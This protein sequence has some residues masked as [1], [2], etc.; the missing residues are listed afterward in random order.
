MEGRKQGKIVVFGS[1]EL[2]SKIAV[3]ER[4]LIERALKAARDT[5][6][7][8]AEPGIRHQTAGIF[9]SM[10]GSQEAMIVAD[11]NTY[12][13]AGRAVEA[14]FARE[15]RALRKP[16]IFG[17]HI[18]A[19]IECVQELVA[20]LR[21]HDAIPV[22]V[23]SG[24][25]NDLTKL[26]AH[27]TNRQYMVVGTAA[28]MDGYSAYG[29][30][31][32]VAGSKD[33][34]ECPAPLA[35]LADL[36]VI[37]LAPREMNAWGYGDLMAKVVAGADWILADAAGVEA[38]S[39]PVWETVQRLLRSWIGSPDAIA[40]SDPTALKHLVHGLVMSG[41]AMQSCLNS[42]PA[43]GAEH[44]FSHLWDMQ[45]HTFQGK[46]PSHGFKVGIGVLASLAL[47][48]DLLKRDMHCF[49]IE[50]AVRAWPSMNELEQ[51]MHGLFGAG[52]LKTRGIEETRAKYVSGD[53]LRMQLTRL[54]E[55]WTE[56]RS[57]LIGQLIPFSELRDMLRRAGCPFEPMQ[58]GI[59]AARLRLSFQQCCFMRRRYTVLDVMQRLGLFDSALD[60]IF[61]PQGPWPIEGEELL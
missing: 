60:N 4:E 3:E 9:S 47:Q 56:V 12:E 37:A 25:V 46:T 10:F 31:I 24:T 49:D 19:N 6:Y 11:E 30:S 7:F 41:F 27:Q 22:A 45:H 1:H 58:I 61:G 34:I 43:S 35:V 48:E 38:I 51:K 8:A 55:N 28:S 52:A 50:A 39:P 21:E 14:S 15:N 26:A 36:D 59:S 32:T 33:T 54:K 29:A 57:K 23:G 13:A 17:P 20:A 5:R 40:A 44:Q 42:R 18:Y 2:M 53:A 16:F